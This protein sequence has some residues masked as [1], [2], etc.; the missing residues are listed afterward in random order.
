MITITASTNQS[1]TERPH[2][3]L[4]GFNFERRE[5]RTLNVDMAVVNRHCTDVILQTHYTV[6]KN[7]ESLFFLVN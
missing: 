6:T 2:E 3:K 1:L 5:R 7:H 4:K